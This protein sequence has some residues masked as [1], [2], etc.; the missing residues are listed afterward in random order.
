V[1]CPRC[2]LVNP[3]A[4][5]RCD[6]GHDFTTG[7]LRPLAPFYPAARAARI[8]VIM[9]AVAV[10]VDVVAVGAGLVQAGLVGRIAAG[11]TFPPEQLQAADA[12]QRLIGIAQIVTLL[13][14]A[15]AFL[16][17]LHLA[18]GNLPAL[19]VV[20]RFSRTW[21]VAFFLI[22]IVNLFRPYQ[23]VR[24]LWR[25]SGGRGAIVAW[26]WTAHLGASF[27][28]AQSLTLVATAKTP[29]EFLIAT[30]AAVAADVCGAVAPALALAI[31]RGIDRGP[32][33]LVGRR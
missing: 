32:A 6:C 4:A 16:R 17:W 31:V 22:P 27:V 20:P 29:S 11:Q 30:W 23:V 33:R 25:G 10:V 8:A 24:E 3:P 18:Y 28:G 2:G 1:N 12:R 13:A 7:L 21:S 26:W 5:A 19:G 15:V 14:G 9:L